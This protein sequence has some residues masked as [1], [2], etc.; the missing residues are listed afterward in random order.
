MPNLDL[1]ILTVL[2][3]EYQAVCSLLP[4]L[5]PMQ[6]TP[7]ASNLYAWKSGSLRNRL[8]GS[9]QLAVG[10]LG[11]PGETG[12]ALAV[13]DA[14]QRWRP[15]YI[16]FVG[17]AGGLKN[18]NK[19]DVIIA[20]II[21]PYEYGKLEKRFLPRP[22]RTEQTDQALLTSALA[23]IKNHRWED[24]HMPDPPSPTQPKITQGVVA[25]GEKVIDD[26]TNEFFEAVLEANPRLSAVE[27]EGAGAAS[28]IEQAQARGDSVG[29]MMVR[30]ISDLPRGT[31]AEVPG[32]SAAGTVP[33]ER[34]TA[35]RDR[36]K[37][38]AAA[39]AAA[40]LVGWIRDGLPVAPTAPRRSLSEAQQITALK[41]DPKNPIQPQKPNSPGHPPDQ[42]V[43]KSPSNSPSFWSQFSKQ[44]SSPVWQGIAGIA[45]ILGIVIALAAWLYPNLQARWWP[46]PTGAS[47]AASQPAP[48]SI[49]VAASATPL[50]ATAAYAGAPGATALS[51]SA[52]TAPRCAYPSELGDDAALRALIQAESQALADKDLQAVGR[53]FAPGAFIADG[54]KKEYWLDPIARYRKYFNE[55]RSGA[56]TRTAITAVSP[57]IQA[58]NAWYTSGNLTHLVMPDG[59][60]ADYPNSS[61]SDHWEFTRDTSGCWLI[62]A[63]V[64][65]ASSY[66]FPCYCKLTSGD[67]PFQCLVQ[68]EGEAVVQ[69]NPVLVWSIF[70]PSA[71]V[72]D[73][74]EKSS[75]N[76]FDYYF[77]NLFPNYSFSSAQHFD[78]TRQAG[79]QYTAMYTSGSR[80]AFTDRSGAPITYS[81]PNPSDAWH[82]SRSPAACWVIDNFAFNQP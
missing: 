16:F 20:D 30:G 53:I 70:S 7:T 18:L 76:V 43:E 11:R 65:N 22:D 47:S 1:V 23:Y 54:A 12:S 19:G 44:L 25:S 28:A 68:A 82:F 60:A 26:P 61:G 75:S 27:M 3:E 51:T 33:A 81:N 79:D 13:Q 42:L 52:P 29:F 69:K 77:K 59:K 40:F 74:K 38:Y 9:Y 37:Q 41:A 72:I 31:Q 50:A 34:G 5:K 35:E 36:W 66:S 71:L 64:F 6:G 57:G 2:H 39:A 10:M 24:F 17:I 78:L 46:A 63:L 56:V 45:T 32:L 49:S 62:R 14:I 21:F 8:G 55:I 48:T 73:G 80:G 58:N 15:R 4:D 67:E